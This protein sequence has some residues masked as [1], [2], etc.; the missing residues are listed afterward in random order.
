M[1]LFTGADIFPVILWSMLNPQ[2]DF[3]AGLKV[4]GGGGNN[5]NIFMKVKNWCCG[6]YRV[7]ETSF[8]SLG[9]PAGAVD[10]PYIRPSTN[11]IFV[12]LTAV[13]V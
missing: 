2:E 8:V 11:L 3:V 6:F 7:P 4:Q 12:I 5:T 9:D 13:M 1:T 10:I